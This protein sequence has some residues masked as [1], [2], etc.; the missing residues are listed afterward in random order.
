VSSFIGDSVCEFDASTVVAV[1]STFLP[2]DSEKYLTGMASE[3][4]NLEVVKV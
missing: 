4:S 3:G 1:Q 2:E